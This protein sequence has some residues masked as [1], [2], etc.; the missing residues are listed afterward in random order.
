MHNKCAA[1][2]SR[3]RGLGL[4]ASA[5]VPRQYNFDDNRLSTY[6]FAESQLGKVTEKLGKVTKFNGVRT[7]S[8]TL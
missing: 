6:T 8:L 2:I 4:K 5:G 7:L 1:D 3:K